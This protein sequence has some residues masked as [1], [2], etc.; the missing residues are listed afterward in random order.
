MSDVYVELKS[1]EV[2]V[3]DRTHVLVV[4]GGPAGTSAAIA[5]A[6]AGAEKVILLERYGYLGGMATGGQV[7]LIPPLSYRENIILRGIILEIVDRLHTLPNAFC[8][9][10]KGLTGSSDIHNLHYWSKYY[11]MV[12]HDK[13]CYGG[14]TDPD[15]FRIIL[16]EIAEKENIKFYFNCW[17]SEAVVKDGRII[18]VCFESKQGRFAILADVVID[19]TGD[20]DICA[21][22]G[23]GY[24]L[25]PIGNNRNSSMG[26]VYRLGNADFDTFAEWKRT[27]VTEWKEHVTQINKICGYASAVFPTGRNDV[28]WVDNWI[29]N[30]NCLDIQ[31]LGMAS[32]SVIKTILPVI[33]YLRDSAVPGLNNICLF[34]IASQT[35]TRGSR[36]IHGKTYLSITDVNVG[37]KFDDV[38][39]VFPATDHVTT[40]S[41]VQD[42][43]HLGPQQFPLGAMIPLG[44]ENLIQAG[45]AFCSDDAANNLYNLIP[46][47][48]AM[49]QAAGV[50]AARAVKDGEVPSKVNHRKVQR[51]LVKQDVYLPDEIH[52]QL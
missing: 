20:A 51:D 11:N 38:V 26:L 35:G 23:V 1:K 24:D 18:G 14:Y 32:R 39:A 6:R 22:A 52:C 4:G 12:W 9:P 42:C 16:H 46:H 43:S 33:N 44:I 8:G 2:R 28:V 27:H 29:T 48:F 47:C 31:S 30:G 49:G 34:D 7:I 5:A 36:R 15:Y 21:S 45:R 37:K 17:S 50:L 19:C 41:G 25:N 10:S 13:I 3:V 40:D